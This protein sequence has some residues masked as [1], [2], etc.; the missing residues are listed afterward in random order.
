MDI[1]GIDGESVDWINLAQDMVHQPNTVLYRSDSIKGGHM[2]EV[3]T[4][5]EI[6]KK[7]IR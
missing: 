7:I 3:D 6:K 4:A 2:W 5:V 1:K